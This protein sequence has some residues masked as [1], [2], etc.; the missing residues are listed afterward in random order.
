MSSTWMP[1]MA[2]PFGRHV[3]MSAKFFLVRRKNRSPEIHELFPLLTGPAGF[4]ISFKT[5]EILFR[6]F[7]IIIIIFH[8]SSA[9]MEV[10]NVF[11]SNT[12]LHQNVKSEMK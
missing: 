12:C 9:S 11:R 2:Y 5:A 6:I 4:P 8:K 3:E 1:D 7:F 10:S